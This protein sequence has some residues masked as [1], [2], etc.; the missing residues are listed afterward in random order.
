MKRFLVKG[1]KGGVKA[2]WGVG[3]LGGVEALLLSES[4]LSAGL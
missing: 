1:I 4:D 2:L 3:A